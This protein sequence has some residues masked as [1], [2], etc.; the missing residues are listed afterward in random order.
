MKL[1]GARKPK[2]N[3][4]IEKRRVLRTRKGLA[5]SKRHKYETHKRRQR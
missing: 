3:T 4:K 2:K 1:S 5:K